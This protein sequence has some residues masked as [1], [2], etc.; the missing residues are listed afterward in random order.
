M[1]FWSCRELK[2]G[3]EVGYA[4]IGTCGRFDV[5]SCNFSTVVSV[6]EKTGSIKLSNGKMFNSNGKERGSSGH[7]FLRLLEADDLRERIRQKAKRDARSSD[8]LW[9]RDLVEKIRREP[10][11]KE[12]RRTVLDMVASG[13]FDECD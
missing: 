3:D 4:N 7:V 9:L 13:I 11:S 6:N 8:H 10:L 2:V 1:K 12:D 5:S